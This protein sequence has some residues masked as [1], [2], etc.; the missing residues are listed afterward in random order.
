VTWILT[1]EA[2]ESDHRVVLTVTDN[3]VGLPIERDRIVEPYMT[4]R[5]RGTGLGLAIVKKIIE[6]HFGTIAFRDRARRRHAGDDLLRYPG[7]RESA[8]RVQRSNQQRTARPAALT[9]TGSTS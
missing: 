4:T 2:N 7:E 6:E 3:G 9:R 5:S 8:H 1:I